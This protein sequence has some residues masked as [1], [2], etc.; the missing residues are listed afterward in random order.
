MNECEEVSNRK[1]FV[2]KECGRKLTLRNVNQV[3]SRK[4]KVDDCAI[5]DKFEIKCDYLLIA[6]GNEIFIELKGTDID[7]ALKQIENTIRLIGKKSDIGNRK[8]Y[9]ISTRVP[10]S[11]SEVQV[12]QSR[13][14]NNFKSKL[15]IHSSPHKEDY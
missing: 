6:E 5:K 14:R 12:L 2:F 9:I 3:E 4:I 10:L 8:A 15:I 7:H 11:S 1:E 13:H